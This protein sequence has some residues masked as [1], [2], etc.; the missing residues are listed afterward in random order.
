MSFFDEFKTFAMRGNAVD[1]AIGV[2]IGAA[3]G[4]IV[5]SL[6]NDILMPPI[7]MLL[8][9]VDFKD[10]SITL[11]AASGAQPAVALN[12]GA[13]INTIVDFVIIAFVIFLVVKGMNQLIGVAPATTKECPDCAMTIPTQAKK[14]GHC[15][16]AL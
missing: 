11:K 6:V 8:G 12:Y 13:F 4:K 5:S 3:F 14:C 15:G 10:L 9:G 2:I 7:G 16:K 1:L